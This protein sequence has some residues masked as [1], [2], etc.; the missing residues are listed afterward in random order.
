MLKRLLEQPSGTSSNVANTGA[1]HATLAFVTVTE[2]DH[3]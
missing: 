1:A 2:S 3:E